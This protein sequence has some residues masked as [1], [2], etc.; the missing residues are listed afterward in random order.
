[1]G[2][3]PKR[4]KDIGE[5]DAD[6]DKVKVEEEI[7]THEANKAEKEAII[8]QLKS[9]YGFNWKSLLGIKGDADTSTL[10]SLLKGAKDSMSTSGLVAKNITGNARA[11]STGVSVL[12]PR[13]ITRA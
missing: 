5:L 1:M 12:P 8:K 7:A 4:K 6:L 9:Q 11:P 2:F 10:R 13:G 3:L